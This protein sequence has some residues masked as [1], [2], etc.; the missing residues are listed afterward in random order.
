MYHNPWAQYAADDSA[1]SALTWTHLV[2]DMFKVHE[3]D[4]FGSLLG[5]RPNWPGKLF[6]DG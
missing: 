6:P 3:G 5:V 4:N 1:F 2:E